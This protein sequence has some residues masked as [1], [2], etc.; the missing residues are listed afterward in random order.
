MSVKSLLSLVAVI[1]VMAF[2]AGCA[3]PPQAD[4]DAAKAALEAAKAVGADRYVADVFNAA[5]DSL[6][7][8]NT[9]IEAQNSKFALGRNYKKAQALLAAAT[10]LANEAKDKTAARKEEVKAEALKL[11]EDV[12]VALKDA[13]KLIKRAPRGKEGRAAIDAMQAELKAV[14]TSVAEAPALI[15]SGDYITAHDRLQAGLA[16]VNSIIDELKQAIAKKAGR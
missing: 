2:M 6:N 11:I 13:G 4:L 9:E 10:R 7:A 14:E 5:Q 1:L 8:A 16:K 3:K 12:K 15:E